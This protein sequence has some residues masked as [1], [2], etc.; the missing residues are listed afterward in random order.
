MSDDQ[1]LESREADQMGEK[2]DHGRERDHLIDA[3]TGTDVGSDT[4]AGS[5]QGG[6]ATGSEIDPDSA[7]VNR[8]L[9]EQGRD[10][11]RRETGDPNPVN[12]VGARAKAATDG[13]RGADAATG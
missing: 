9:R 8:S 4:R 11:D 3:L 7:A 6:A 13:P 10:A 1:N 5:L 2:P 12:N